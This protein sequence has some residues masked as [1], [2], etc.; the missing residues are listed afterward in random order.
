MIKTTSLLCI[1]NSLPRTAHCQFERFIEDDLINDE[2][3]IMATSV[4]YHH[5]S[6]LFCLVWLITN[7]T[8][9]HVW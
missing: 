9:A 1:Q 2:G 3:V 7:K 4:C 5:M 6:R 8:F